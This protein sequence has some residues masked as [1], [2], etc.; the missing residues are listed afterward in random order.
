MYKVFIVEFVFQGVD[1]K[2]QLLSVL[3]QILNN[4]IYGL[5]GIICFYVI[6]KEIE[7]GRGLGVV[8][9][10]IVELGNGYGYF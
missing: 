6:V 2:C 5:I 8:C 10:Y 4:D 9:G 1:S 3:L 7:G